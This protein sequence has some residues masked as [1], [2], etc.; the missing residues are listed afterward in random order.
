MREWAAGF[1]LSKSWRQTRA[2][3]LAANPLCER[4][5]RAGCVRPAE[6]VHHRRHITRTTINDTRITLD[7]ANL[8]SLCNDCHNKEHHTTE[9]IGRYTINADGS[10]SPPSPPKSSRGSN[11]AG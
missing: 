5:E 8:E 3:Y 9:R 11:R 2:A 1:Y 4:C 6:M 10:I 7:W